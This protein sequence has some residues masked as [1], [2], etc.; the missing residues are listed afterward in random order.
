M[1]VIE[2]NQSTD[3][4]KENNHGRSVVNM[5]FDGSS[6]KENTSRSSTPVSLPQIFT[7]QMNFVTMINN[8]G[9]RSSRSQTP[10]I[11]DK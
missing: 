2:M 5:Y 7:G 9:R 6:R 1:Q 8:S 11:D 3:P 10:N 4:A